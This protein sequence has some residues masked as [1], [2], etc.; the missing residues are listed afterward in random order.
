MKKSILYSLLILCGAALGVGLVKLLPSNSDSTETA[1]HDH[2][3]E[4]T[5]WTC[6]MHPEIEED[7][8][9]ACPICGMDLTPK[10]EAEDEID[11]DLFTL[12]ERA[13][14]LANIQTEKVSD[15][16]S[17]SKINR[18]TGKI[19][20]TDASAATQS[21]YVAGR[22]ENLQ[23][24]TTGKAVQKG[25]VLGRIYS[26]ELLSAQQEL[27][28]A[29][30]RKEHNPKLFKAVSNK[31]KQWKWS[32]KQID[33]L[34]KTE[35]V[36]PYFPIQAMVSGEVIEK[37]V[38]E[39][40]YVK[41]GQELFK[42]SDLNNLW[43][44]I[45][46][47]ET[48]AT[49]FKEGDKV[50]LFTS[51]QSEITGK[52]DLVHPLVDL[53]TRTVQLRVEIPN[54]DRKLKPGMLLR[55]EIAQQENEE[56]EVFVT[57]SAVLWTGKRSVVYVVNRDHNQLHF[58]MRSVTL[59]HRSGDYYEIL[60]GLSSEEEVVTHGAFTLDAAAQLQ[61]KPSMMGTEQETQLSKNEE[62]QLQQVMEYYFKLK[63]SFVAS[64]PENVAQQAQHIRTKIDEMHL[65]LEAPWAKDWHAAL[66]AWKKI[67]NEKDLGEQR[68][69]FKKLNEHLIP[70]AKHIRNHKNTWYMQFCP[71]ADENNGGYWISLKKEIRNPYYGD[72]MLDC[73]SIE[74]KW[75]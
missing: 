50:N 70:I 23:V 43:G 73:G 32:Q 30:K 21:A 51:G 20:A 39:G 47:P 69:S 25:Q 65:H 9:G 57:K 72:K 22:I 66:N 38:S 49:Q 24:N 44:V 5:I 63:D 67:A 14:S 7:Q 26:P 41:G 55:A 31:L 45:D 62:K 75:N 61:N 2:A 17:T 18:Y 54:A 15:T 34:L 56:H 74:E 48:E 12:G 53:A 33:D 60:D 64:N 4:E 46:V 42:I 36:Q 35:E 3:K 28:S 40:S 29:Y 13:L 19:Q 1:D 6:S 58:E 27:L 16:F 10:D 11:D 71:M 8:P 37:L 68:L 59:G 52:V